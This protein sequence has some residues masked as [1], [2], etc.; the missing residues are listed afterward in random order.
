MSAENAAESTTIGVIREFIKDAI[1]SQSLIP[2]H[3]GNLFVRTPKWVDERLGKADGDIARFKRSI[4]SGIRIVEAE[5]GGLL[6]QPALV[7]ALQDA[8]LPLLIVQ[9]MPAGIALLLARDNLGSDGFHP[10]I[11]PAC[12]SSR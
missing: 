3:Q 8:A 7:V 2:F 12:R 11:L 5:C 9:P 6:R 10:A 4:E 1:K